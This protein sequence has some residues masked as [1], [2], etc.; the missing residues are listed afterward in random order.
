MFHPLL[1]ARWPIKDP[2]TETADA[3]SRR[4][5]ILLPA[6]QTYLLKTVLELIFSLL[7]RRL[8]PW[9]MHSALVLS[10]KIL[11]VEIVVPTAGVAAVFRFDVFWIAVASVTSVVSELEMLRRDVAFPF[12]LG[13]ESRRTAI[14]GKAADKGS[15]RVGCHATSRILLSSGRRR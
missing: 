1:P 8:G 11:S 10:E 5:A 14:W 13:A 15:R 2:V 4:A 6:S 7:R 9:S 3:P 12:V